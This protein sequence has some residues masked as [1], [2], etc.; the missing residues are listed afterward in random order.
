MLK[1]RFFTPIVILAAVTGVH[2]AAQSPTKLVAG[3]HLVFEAVS[4]KPNKSLDGSG[5]TSTMS[6]RGGHMAITNFSLRMFLGSAFNFDLNQAGRQI[7]GLPGW[8]DSERFDMQAEAP[9]SPTVEQKRSM[10]LDLLGERFK[11]TFHHESRPLPIFVLVMTNPG[12]FG[13]QLHAHTDDAAC[14]QSSMARGD[15]A[16]AATPPAESTPRSP[17]EAAALAVQTV[18]CGRVGGGLLQGQR[19]QAWAGGRRVTMEMLADSL[20][21][22]MP[23]DRLVRGDRTGLSG[24]FDFTM[25]WNPQIQDLA[26]SPVDSPGTSFLQ[27]LREQVGLKLDPQTGPVEVVVIDHVER[28]TEN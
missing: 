12:K 21:S 7:L 17:A 26:S 9:G 3:K 13:P 8:G 20:G 15:A 6:L 25:E 23:M 11:L 18:P 28:P 4:I 22:L 10:L 5:A 19:D 2:G 27:S 16:S 14:Q 1:V 24:T